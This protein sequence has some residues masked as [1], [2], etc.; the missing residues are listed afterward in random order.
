MGIE[1][2]LRLVGQ[3]VNPSLAVGDGV[4]EA[5]VRANDEEN[6]AGIMVRLL[7]ATSVQQTQ[8]TMPENTGILPH[9]WRDSGP[10]SPAGSLS[11]QGRR[12]SEPPVPL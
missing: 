10:I 2:E 6:V 4:E 7:F 8:L 11:A 1:F 3:S 12:R 5:I 9:L